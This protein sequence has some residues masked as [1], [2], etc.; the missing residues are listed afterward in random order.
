MGSTRWF[1]GL[2]T[3]W[4]L[5]PAPLL[6]QPADPHAA[7][8]ERPSVATHAAT[9]APGWLEVEAGWERTRASGRFGDAGL[10]LALKLGLT[11]RSQLT[12]ATAVNRP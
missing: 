9:V 12:I 8:P 6:A 7:L 3:A 4:V 11:P 1:A 5:G 2:L 10:P